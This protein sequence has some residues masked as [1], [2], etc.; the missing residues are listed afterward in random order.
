MMDVVAALPP[1]DRKTTAEVRHEHS[2]E[3]ISDET[4]GDTKMTSIMSHEHD[5]MLFQ[6]I[7]RSR[8]KALVCMTYPENAEKG[9]RHHIPL[10]VKC[11][12]EQAEQDRESNGI[13][14][15]SYVRAVVEAFILDSLM[16]SLVF[17]NDA[18]L[19]LGIEWRIFARGFIPFLAH[20][21]EGVFFAVLSIMEQCF[22]RLVF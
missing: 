19:R 7:S 9:G 20:Q 22:H 6:L 4:V 12:K 2:D 18:S 21:V 10:R 14:A 11:K 17:L 15:I 16:K 5:L 8:E 3:G 1:S 13:P